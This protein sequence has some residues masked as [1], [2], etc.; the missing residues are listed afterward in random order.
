MRKFTETP[1]IR[2][3]FLFLG[4]SLIALRAYSLEIKTKV[5]DPMCN[6]ELYNPENFRFLDYLNEFSS[7]LEAYGKEKGKKTIDLLLFVMINGL[8]STAQRE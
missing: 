7:E 3:I 6:Q 1:L 2:L 4:V 5:V 8:N